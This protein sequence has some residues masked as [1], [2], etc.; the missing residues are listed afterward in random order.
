MD[1]AGIAS[2]ASDMKAAE[3][4][5]AASIK[6]M[7][8]ALDSQKAGLSVLAPLDAAQGANNAAQGAMKGSMIDILA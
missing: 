8:M 6:V 3:T 1:L 4:Q 7:K 2:A 5:Y